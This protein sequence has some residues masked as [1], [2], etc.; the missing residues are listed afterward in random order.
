MVHLLGA[1]S[2]TNQPLNRSFIFQ[3]G[4]L[5][6]TTAWGSVTNALRKYLYNNETFSSLYFRNSFD[7]LTGLE[8]L[9]LAYNELSSLPDRMFKDLRSL[10]ISHLYDNNLNETMRNSILISAKKHCPAMRSVSRER[11]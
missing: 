5:S 9:D 6:A 3:N 10:Q 1:G 4:E 7:G 8:D 2:F 11:S